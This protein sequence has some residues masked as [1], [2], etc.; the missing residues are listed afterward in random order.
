VNSYFAFLPITVALVFVTGCTNSQRTGASIDGAFRSAV[1]PDVQTLVSVKLDKLK[2][3]DLYHRHRQELALPQFDAMSERAGLDPRRDVS[4]ILLV[5]NGKHLLVLAQ[6]AFSNAQLEEKLTVN[7]ARRVPYKNFT[8]FARGS[9]SVSFPEHGLAIASSTAVVQSALDLRSSHGGSLPAEME[10]RLAEVPADAQIWEVSAGGL[11]AANFPLRSDLDSAL[12]NIATVVSG[13]S[14]GLR[15]DSGSHLR[16]RVLCKSPE[17]AQ[18]VNDAMRG[19][20]GFARLSTNDNE[21]DLLRMWDAVSIT[22][23]DRV[24][25]VQADL[26]ADLTDKVI[27]HLGGLRSRAGSF[28]DSH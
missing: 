4:N 25:R 6:G 5:W 7:G 23:D 18:R 2:A 13:T 1:P 9:D 22:K 20:I 3:T 26:P 8:L 24:V 16:A 15:F 17:G 21:M 27:A 28:L 14:F 19:L 11:P 12:S 10:D